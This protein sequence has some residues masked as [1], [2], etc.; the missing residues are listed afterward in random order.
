M[1]TVIAIILTAVCFFTLG[2]IV[3]D[4]ILYGIIKA[5]KA[6]E[7]IE[8]ARKIIERNQSIFKKEQN[9]DFEI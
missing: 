8:L 6:D 9:I 2:L 7:Q 4:L 3:R 1:I 5:K